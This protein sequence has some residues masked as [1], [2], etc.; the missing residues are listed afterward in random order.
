M[1]HIEAFYEFF[2][3]DKADVVARYKAAFDDLADRFA[4]TPA[5]TIRWLEETPLPPG[6]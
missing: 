5:A 3:L 1:V 6:D 4:L 2:I